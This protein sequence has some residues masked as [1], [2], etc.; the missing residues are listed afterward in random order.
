[1]L[2]QRTLRKAAEA[3]GDVDDHPAA[4]DAG[5]RRSLARPPQRSRRRTLSVSTV[6]SRYGTARLLRARGQIR[7]RAA[8]LPFG[9]GLRVDPVPS[10]Q[11]SQA[12]LTTLYRSMDLL[13][14]GGAAVKNLAQSASLH[15]GE[16]N[17]PSKPGTKQ[18]VA[19]RIYRDGSP[20][21]QSGRRITARATILRVN[22]G[23]KT[24]QRRS[25]PV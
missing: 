12:L 24:L 9:H 17:A 6:C 21:R 3:L 13:C 14:R 7:D 18:L 19:C 4:D 25:A 22:C 20:S 23:P 8:L 10:G 2:W 1:L 11:S 5:E 16:N 15:A